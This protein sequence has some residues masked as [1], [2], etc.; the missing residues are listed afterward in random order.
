MWLIHLN[1]HNRH[2]FVIR[3]ESELNEE[4]LDYFKEHNFILQFYD[5]GERNNISCAQIKLKRS[6]VQYVS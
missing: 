3:K 1:E 2:D 4:I 6:V 5:R